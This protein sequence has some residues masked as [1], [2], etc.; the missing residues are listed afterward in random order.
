MRF[1]IDSPSLYPHSAIALLTARFPDGTTLQGSGTVVGRND[2][3]TAAHVVY[4]AAHG[5]AA[6][7]VWATPGFSAVSGPAFGNFDAEAVGVF[8]GADP[9]GDGLIYIG[10]GAPGTLGGS[11]LDLAVLGFDEALGDLTGTMALDPGFAVGTAVMSGYPASAGGGPVA[12]VGPVVQ[13]ATDSFL[14]IDALGA[15]PGNSGGPIWSWGPAGPAVAGVVSTGLAAAD[16]SGGYGQV[17]AWM[18]GNDT[19]LAGLPAA[20][21]QVWLA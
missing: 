4:D 5:G 15:E 16:L 20:A 7:E 14:W 12:A 10:D 13:H 3:L 18:G 6:T 9:E 11:E 17:L 19:L 2:V 21:D 1:A 8:A